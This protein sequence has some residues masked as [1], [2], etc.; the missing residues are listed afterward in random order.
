MGLEVALVGLA[1]AAYGTKMQMDAADDMAEAQEDAR[2]AQQANQAQQRMEERRKAARKSRIARAR[3]M[4]ASENSGT[5]GSSG[6]MGAIGSINTQTAASRQGIFQREDTSNRLSAANQGI[7]NAQASATEGG[8]Y[9][10]LGG[11]I[12]SAAGGFSA[13]SSA[14][15][16]TPPPANTPQTPVMNSYGLTPADYSKLGR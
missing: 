6:E 11:S 8:A 16:G 15:L 2:N 7:S 13:F 12:F 9:S 3:I 4:Q 10:K 5:G 14:P 1:L